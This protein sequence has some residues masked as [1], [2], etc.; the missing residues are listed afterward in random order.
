M[1]PQTDLLDK[2]LLDK[3]GYVDTNMKMETS[4][5]GFYAIGDVRNTPFR[6]VV[7]A[8]SDGAIAANAASEYIDE[9]NNNKY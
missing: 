7:T 1:L 6:Q 9:I 2:S 3:W 8:V 5:R 4:L